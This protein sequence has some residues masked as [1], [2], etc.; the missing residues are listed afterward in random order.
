M[1][2]EIES[3]KTK[4]SKAKFRML[5]KKT[6]I[7]KSK[8]QPSE[9]DSWHAKHN[10]ANWNTANQNWNIK[11]KSWNHI[12]EFFKK[13]TWER[14]SQDKYPNTEPKTWHHKK[15]QSTYSK[16]LQMALYKYV[17]PSLVSRKLNLNNFCSHYFSSS[18]SFSAGNHIKNVCFIEGLKKLVLAYY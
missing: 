13:P 16:T 8:K 6:N 11:H 5:H 10:A 18:R 17:V 2:I 7:T 9:H 15:T 12:N 1:I 4:R 14:N 3:M